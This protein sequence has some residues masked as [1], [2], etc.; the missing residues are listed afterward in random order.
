MEIGYRE[1]AKARR[2]QRRKA[3]Q[4]TYLAKSTSDGFMKLLFFFSVRAYPTMK[5]P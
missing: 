1:T 3:H 2:K 5:R 4:M